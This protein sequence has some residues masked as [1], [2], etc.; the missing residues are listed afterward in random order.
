MEFVQDITIGEGEA[1]PPSTKFVKTWR[2]KNNGKKINKI[3]RGRKR[4]GIRPHWSQIIF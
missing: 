4:I 1:V 2:L 3:S